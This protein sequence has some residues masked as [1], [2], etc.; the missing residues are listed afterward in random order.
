MSVVVIN[1]FPVICECASMGDTCFGNIVSFISSFTIFIFACFAPMLIRVNVTLVFSF[2]V[3]CGVSCVS[4]DP[5]TNKSDYGGL[6]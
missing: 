3:H 2:L 4:F 5:L 1:C 6:F